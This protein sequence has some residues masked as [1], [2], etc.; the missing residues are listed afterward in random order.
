MQKNWIPN[1]IDPDKAKEFTQMEGLRTKIL[2]GLS[3]EKMMMVLNYTLPGH[4]VPKHSHSHEQIGM[5][6]SGKAK[7]QIGEEER[8]I[9]KGDFYC[10]PSNVEHSDTCIGNEPFVMLDIFYPVRE[11]FVNKLRSSND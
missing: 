2:T 9:K 11:D 1:F 10:I 6:Y 3:G 7:L 8:I 5:V 4:E